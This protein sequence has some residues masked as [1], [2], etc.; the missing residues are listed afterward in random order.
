[1]VVHRNRGAGSGEAWTSGR[2]GHASMPFTGQRSSESPFPR[3]LD[4]EKGGASSRRALSSTL[5]LLRPRPPK[6]FVPDRLLRRTDLPCIGDG[7]DHGTD[8]PSPAPR[9]TD[10]TVC[11]WWL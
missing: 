8:D 9:S 11:P 6:V 7:E 4:V 10:Q 3:R 1:M 2:L 5:R